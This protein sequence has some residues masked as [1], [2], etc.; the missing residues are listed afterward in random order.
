M[1]SELKYPLVFVSHDAGAANH[2]IAWIA[3]YNFFGEFRIYFKGPA[4][5]NLKNQFP[6]IKIF[7]TLESSL[8]KAKT[9]ICGTGWQTDIEYN[10]LKI[11]NELNIESIAIIDHWVN[12][13]TRFTRNNIEILPNQIWVMDSEAYSIA[14]KTFKNVKISKK[15]NTYLSEIL[16]KI[17]P[18][19][20]VKKN[21]LLY[22]LEPA[23]SNWGKNIPGEF[24]AF[25]YM[26]DNWD[27][28]NI[29][30]ETEIILRPH[31][32]DS[33]EKYDSLLQINRKIK[34]DNNTLEQSI[35]DSKWICGC[36]SFA[37][38]IG[39]KSN[40]KVFCSLPPWATECRL[41]HDEIIHI[42]KLHIESI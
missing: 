34:I 19:N 38:I 12:Y 29:P 41:P 42:K 24:Q 14:K 35:S 28:L 7:D 13:K 39:I 23:R 11:A 16:K 10:A 4:R 22:I 18:I 6:N 27:K 5:K 33:I 9:L 1:F 8:E 32:S 36:E 15:K 30:N 25:N 31:P 26:L 21:K 2:I 17:L 40:R 37:L 20:K 3:K